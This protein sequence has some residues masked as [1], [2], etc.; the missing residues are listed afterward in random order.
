[1]FY[2]SLVSNGWRKKLTSSSAVQQLCVNRKWIASQAVKRKATLQLQLSSTPH[3]QAPNYWQRLP[4]VSGLAAACPAILFNAYHT[5]ERVICEP[6]VP[7]LTLRTNAIQVTHATASAAESSLTSLLNSIK[8]TCQSIGSDVIK[9]A[10]YT[11]RLFLYALFGMPLL[12]LAPT[13]YLLGDAFPALE[14]L[15]WDYILWA[16]EGLG[17]CFIKL[18][19]WASTRPDLFPPRLVQRL[20]RLQ[21]D[22]TVRY[23]SSV[24]EQT[25]T[26]SFGEQ[27]REVLEIDLLHPIGAG[28]VAQ[29]FRGKMRDD[30]RDVAVKMI[31]PHVEELVKVDMELLSVFAYF[32]DQFPSLEILGLGETCRQFGESMRLQLDLRIE[33]R[34]LLQFA[35]KF[36]S[37]KWAVFPEPVQGLVSKHVLVETLLEGAP[38]SSYMNAHCEVSYE[39]GFSWYPIALLLTAMSMI[40]FGLMRYRSGRRSTS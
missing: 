39:G 17:P 6:Q 8:N 16:V 12:G 25:L 33:A 26:E 1:M 13:A 18:S 24:V 22:V 19:Q 15:T 37:D 23:P 28:S 40:S 29:V 10:R 36:T 5:S 27:W 4:F 30:S 31:H 34:N 11:R 20:S 21:C 14:D 7:D 3:G 2:S 38:I 9:L 35:S 32:M